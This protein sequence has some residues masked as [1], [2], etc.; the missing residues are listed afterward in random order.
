MIH[1]ATSAAA[2]AASLLLCAGSTFAAQP[3][4]SA[5]DHPPLVPPLASRASVASG[6]PTTSDVG[7]AASFGRGLVWLGLAAQEV[8]LST[9]CSGAGPYC[10]LVSPSPAT[11][12]FNFQDIA[13]IKLPARAANSLLCYWFSPYLQVN[14]ANTTAAPVVARLNYSPTVTIDN[15]LLSDP[16]LT[17]PTTGLP[18]GGSL[19]TGMTASEHFEVPLSAGSTLYERT[20]DSA[21]CIAG[22]ISQDALTGTYG[23][24]AAQAREFFRRPMTLHLNVRGTAQYVDS[25]SLY[26][27]LRIV[28]D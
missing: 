17:D 14:Y 26:F 2:F 20:R 25:A 24:S 7:D 9:E 1:R 5:A 3:D 19:T 23:L 13:H 10:Q 16:S 4:P 22:L 11:T 15:S 27:G 6:A 12:A 8:D 28:G 18:F 21:V